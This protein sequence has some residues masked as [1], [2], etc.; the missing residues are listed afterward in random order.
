MDITE[1]K[2]EAQINHFGKLYNF[3]ETFAPGHPDL[4]KTI[5]NYGKAGHSCIKRKNEVDPELID[6]YVKQSK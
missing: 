5:E 6:L 4:A 2:P 3:H 1:T